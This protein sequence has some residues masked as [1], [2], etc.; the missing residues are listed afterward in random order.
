MPLCGCLLAARVGKETLAKQ[1][2]MHTDL[3]TGKKS[4]VNGNQR[5]CVWSLPSL[6]A[7]PLAVLAGLG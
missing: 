7:M 1:T 2:H 5:L 6:V 3:K 4:T